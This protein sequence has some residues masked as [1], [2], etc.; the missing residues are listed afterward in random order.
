MRG[1]ARIEVPTAPNFWQCPRCKTPNPWASYLTACVSC[2]GPRPAAEAAVLFVPPPP[3]PIPPLPK[4]AGRLVEIFSWGYLAIVLVILAVVKLLGDRYW[5]ATLL[6]FGPRWIFLFPFP[7]MLLWAS[8]RKRWRAI[9]VQGV[10]LAVV[11]W[12]LM[13][14]R[15]PFLSL[16]SRP[17][18]GT[19]VRILSMN[20]GGAKLDSRDF[21]DLVSDGRYDIVCIQEARADPGLD[22]YFEVQKW[23]HDK[24]KTLWSK[25]PIVEDLGSFSPDAY[26]VR[27]A[28]PARLSRVRIRLDNGTEVVV[29]NAHLPTM[30]YGFEGLWKGNLAWVRYYTDW[31]KR[32][33]E[34]MVEALR[35]TGPAPLILAGD[36][37]MPPDSP[38]MVQIRNHFTSGFEEVGW[39]FGYTRPESYSWIGIDRILASPDCRFISSKVGPRV[40]SDH[41]PIDGVVVVPTK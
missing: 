24:A 37:N 39:G 26:E 32:E 38:F 36:F 25:F 31:R 14:L 28:W 16:L 21:L 23:H 29:A 9:G 17:P 40:G 34:R 10:T 41:R 3:A 19:I 35:S 15:T 33:T 5:P 6:L 22:A 2:G 13:G 7:V 11:L 12:P 8:L 27:G 20:R 30:T 1:N 18:D 4:K